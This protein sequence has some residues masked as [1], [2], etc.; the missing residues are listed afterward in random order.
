MRVG[1]EILARAAA[2]WVDVRKN[3]RDGRLEVGAMLQEYIVSVVKNADGASEADRLKNRWTR[4]YAVEDISDTLGMRTGTCHELVRVAMAV[5]LLSEE[6]CVGALSYESLRKLA[7]LVKRRGIATRNSEP[8]EGELYPSQA[9]E[10]VVKSRAA[11]ARELF[12]KAVREGWSRDQCVDALATMK[13]PR[14]GGRKPAERSPM[15]DRRC[16]PEDRSVGRESPFG[17]ACEAHPRDLAE[18]ISA[19]IRKNPRPSAVAEELLEMIRDIIP[20]GAAW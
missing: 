4:E 7:V 16:T 19:M 10:W 6:G 12:L 15:P 1:S 2:V 11:G 20:V 13:V 17:I 18:M 14:H 3:F 5:R 8:S 9:E